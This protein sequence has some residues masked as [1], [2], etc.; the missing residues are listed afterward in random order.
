M[1]AQ[2]PVTFPLATVRL[3]ITITKAAFYFKWFPLPENRYDVANF[4]AGI[5]ASFP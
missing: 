1:R 5:F 4:M 3:A 2:R